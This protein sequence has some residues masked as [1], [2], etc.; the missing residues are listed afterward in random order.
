[1]LIVELANVADQVSRALG[2]NSKIAQS[3]KANRS[4]VLQVSQNNFSNAKLVPIVNGNIP[5]NYKSI[6]SA[7]SIEE[8]FYINRSIKRGTG[9]KIII[10]GLEV[11]MSLADRDKIKE[12]GNFQDDFFGNC[13]FQKVEYQF[14]KD[15]AIADILVDNNYIAENTFEERTYNGA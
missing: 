10:R 4:G 12:N 11:P 9:Q 3:L 13:T 5:S 14:S 15:T 7:Q 1:M 8:N 2:Q 6:L